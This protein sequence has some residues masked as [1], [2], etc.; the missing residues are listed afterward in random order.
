MWGQAEGLM[1]LFWSALFV[2]GG[3]GGMVRWKGGRVERWQGGKSG[4]VGR[5]Q[6]GRFLIL[7]KNGECRF[8]LRFH[9]FVS[10]VNQ[11]DE[12]VGWSQDFLARPRNGKTTT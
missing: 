10:D 3:G 11:G 9:L 8:S 12:G 4:I 5:W 1:L 7:F 6:G 2:S